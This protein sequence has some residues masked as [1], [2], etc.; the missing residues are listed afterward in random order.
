M[1]TQTG[2]YTEIYNYLLGTQKKDSY[3]TYSYRN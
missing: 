1:S 3:G 2:S